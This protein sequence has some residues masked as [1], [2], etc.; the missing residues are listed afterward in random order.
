MDCNQDPCVPQF[1]SGVLA[2]PCDVWRND[3]TLHGGEAVLGLI[4]LVVDFA[5]PAEAGRHYQVSAECVVIGQQ[6]TAALRR[7]VLLAVEWIGSN[8]EI[9]AWRAAVEAVVAESVPPLAVVQAL[10]RGQHLIDREAP[11]MLNMRIDEG[12]KALVAVQSAG[13]ATRTVRVGNEG[14]QKGRIR[15]DAIWRNHIQAGLDIEIAGRLLDR[16]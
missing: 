10:L 4:E 1:V 16:K 5:Q 7:F 9:R 3:A 11:H 12:S 15:A 14:N 13:T 6:E 8:D 2:V